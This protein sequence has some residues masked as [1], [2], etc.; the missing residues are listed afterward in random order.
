MV[1]GKLLFLTQAK[2]FGNSFPLHSNKKQNT[3]FI[4]LSLLHI[5]ACVI[6]IWFGTGSCDVFA[7][8]RQNNTVHV[9]VC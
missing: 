4:L 5:Y 6:M 8:S 1:K 9:V 3:A 7:T 2:P